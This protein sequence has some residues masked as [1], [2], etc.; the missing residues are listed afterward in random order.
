MTEDMM[1]LEQPKQ[2]TSLDLFTKPRGENEINLIG[3]VRSLLMQSGLSANVPAFDSNRYIK[4]GVDLGP[5]AQRFLLN[6]FWTLQL[7]QLPV[8]TQDARF[9]LIDTGSYKDWLRLFCDRVLPLVQ[10]HQLPR[11]IA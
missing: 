10:E 11:G 1:T 4:D 3:E 9:C 8:N 5:Q 2:A 6:R 7:M